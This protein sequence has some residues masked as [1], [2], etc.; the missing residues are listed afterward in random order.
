MNIDAISAELAEHHGPNPQEVGAA[1]G[2]EDDWGDLVYDAAVALGHAPETM[3]D[4]DW[5]HFQDVA[6]NCQATNMAA[7][8]A[9]LEAIR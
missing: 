9:H 8:V 6:S 3:S 7:W 2:Y 1:D 5:Q 4:A